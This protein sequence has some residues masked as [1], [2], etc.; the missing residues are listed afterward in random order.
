M[1]RTKRRQ[2][3]GGI[4]GRKGGERSGENINEE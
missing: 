2:E 4:K 1:R 3:E